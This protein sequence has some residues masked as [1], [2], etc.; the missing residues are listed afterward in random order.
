MPCL[1][2]AE[3]IFIHLWGDREPTSLPL[4]FFYSFS[5]FSYFVLLC[6]LSATQNTPNH[7]LRFPSG[8]GSAV[9]AASGSTTGTVS[10]S[11]AG[12]STAP[13]LLLFPKNPCVTSKPCALRYSARFAT[14]STRILRFSAVTADWCSSCIRITSMSTPIYWNGCFG[15]SLIG[16][17]R[18]AKGE[19]ASKFA[20]K[21]YRAR[22]VRVPYM[23]LE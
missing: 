23:T 20:M 4:H 14:S 9:G 8:V 13:P 17:I 10:G 18:S 1:S 6:T 19:F 5:P 16:G 11:G 21:V 7:F 22:E 15:N 12:V 3:L 2:G